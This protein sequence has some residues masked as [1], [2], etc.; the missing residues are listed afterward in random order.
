MVNTKFASS[1]YALSLTLRTVAKN[2]SDA[3]G[4]FEMF[5]LRAHFTDGIF[6]NLRVPTFGQNSENKL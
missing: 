4:L 3:N 1:R 5:L 6:Q 2:M